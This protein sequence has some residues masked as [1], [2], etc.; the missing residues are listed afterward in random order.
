MKLITGVNTEEATS[1]LY[2]QKWKKKDY[3]YSMVLV[4]IRLDQQAE[5][6]SHRPQTNKSS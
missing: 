3:E 4:K 6:N 1:K 2:E 5:R